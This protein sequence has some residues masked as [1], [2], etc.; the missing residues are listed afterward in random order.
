MEIALVVRLQ[1]FDVL[2]VRR[3]W[4][5]REMEMRMEIRMRLGEE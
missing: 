3:R 5:E 4:M 2:D 1:I